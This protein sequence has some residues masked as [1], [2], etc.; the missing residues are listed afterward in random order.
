MGWGVSGYQE[1]MESEGIPIIRTPCVTASWRSSSA[2][3]R[4]GGVGAYIELWGM[5]GVTGL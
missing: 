3:G 2:W 4:L 5:E 1:W